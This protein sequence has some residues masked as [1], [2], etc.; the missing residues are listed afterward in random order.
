MSIKSTFHATFLLITLCLSTTVYAGQ[1]WEYL[2][3]T[4]P[5]LGDDKALTH[6]LN[7]QGERQWELVSCAKGSAKLTCV[8]KRAVQTN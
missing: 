2:V 7:K 8:F 3:K 4:Y 6:A 1:N 5:L